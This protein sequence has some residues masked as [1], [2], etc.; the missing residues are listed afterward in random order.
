MNTTSVSKRGS[1]QFGVHQELELQLWVHKSF[2]QS[3]TEILGLTCAPGLR[4][5]WPCTNTPAWSQ[6]S[7]PAH[8]AAIKCST[9]T[10]CRKPVAVFL[11]D[12]RQQHPRPQGC[13]ESWRGGRS[14]VHSEVPVDS[15]AVPFCGWCLEERLQLASCPCFSSATCPFLVLALGRTACPYL[16]RSRLLQGLCLSTAVA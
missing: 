7:F 16:P 9:A 14:L 6:L 15:G 1:L 2:A 5:A 4:E 3:L 10:K 8:A 12:V 13:G 11:L